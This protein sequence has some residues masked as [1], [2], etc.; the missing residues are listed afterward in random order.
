MSTAVV[1]EGDSAK[2]EVVP[3]QWFCSGLNSQRLSPLS[4]LSR[5][6]EVTGSATSAKRSELEGLVIVRELKHDEKSSF[7]IA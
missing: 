5:V 3:C 6:I 4:R 1:S 7:S 2:Y